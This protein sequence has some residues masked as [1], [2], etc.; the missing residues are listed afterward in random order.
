MTVLDEEINKVYKDLMPYKCIH[1]DSF[2]D[3]NTFKKFI[4]WLSGE[5][6]LHLQDEQDGLT[7]FFPNGFFFI[8]ELESNNAY[9][10]FKIEVKSKCLKN[11][12]QIFNRV[13]SVL[14][15]LKT[16]PSTNRL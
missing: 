9:I 3:L 5:F 8:K 4:N 6:T 10:S 14:T 11:G 12:N 2:E 1:K 13:I 15:H 7:V 16:F